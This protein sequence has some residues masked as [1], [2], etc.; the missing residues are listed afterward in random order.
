MST[1]AHRM[2]WSWLR[3]LAC[4]ALAVPSIAHADVIVSEF[5]ASNNSTLESVTGE[6]PDWIEIYNGSAAAV[7]LTGWYL[8]D[9]PDNLRKWR[10][11]ESAAVPPLASGGYL[12]VFASGAEN[13][14]I[15]GEL[16]AG[17]SLSA[18]GEYLALV[19]PDGQTIAFHYAPQFPPQTTAVS[20]GV[21]T[22][23]GRQ[24]FLASPTPGTENSAVVADP[25]HFSVTSRAFTAPFTL[26]LSTGSPDAEIRYTLD[27]SIP[28]ASS[29]LYASEISI[30]ST[31]K[32]RARAYESG[33]AAGPVAS[34]VFHHLLSGPAAFTS[35]LPLVVIETFGAGDIPHP[36][37]PVRQPCAMM[38]IEPVNGVSTL[39]GE[40]AITSRA[41][42]H[43]RGESTLRSTGSKPNLSLETWGEVV[44]ETRRIE[45]FGM[46]AESDWILYAP[47][48]IDTAM[49]RNP[50]IYEVSN[51]AGEYAVR[52]R[53]VEVFLN[54]GGGSISNSDYFGLYVF[55]ER[56]KRREG[57]VEVKKLTPDAI[58][59]PEITGGYIWKKDKSDPDDQIIAAAGKDLIAVYP[60][61]MPAVQSDWLV[62]HLNTIDAAIPHGN[63]AE[64]ID[65]VSFADHH[66]L[67][68]FANNADGLN[69]STFYHK[70]RNGPVRMGPIWDFD[71][72][73]ACDIDA[74]ASNPEVWSLA[75][76]QMFFFH[77]SGPLWFRSL[78]FNSP[79]FWIVWV[80]RWQAMRQGPLSDAAITGRIERHRTEIS[81]A[82]L[83]NY[84]RWS[85]VLNADAWSGKV[86]AMH[87]HVLT[88]AN[89]I[90]D[91]LVT[92]PVFNH[93]G[94]LV[95]SGM[96]LGIS[97]PQSKFFTLDGSDPRAS[98]GSPAG[99]PYTAPITITG[100]TLV[101]ARAWNGQAFVNAPAT[102]PWSALT[103]AMFVVEPVPLAITEIMYHPRPPQSAA[104]AGFSTSDFEFIEIMN[105]GDSPCIL[106]GVKLLD[107]VGFDFTTGTAGV[108]AAGARGVVVANLDAFKARYPHWAT[109]NILGEFTGKLHNIGGK[110][111]L[112]YDTA[113]VIKLADFSYANDWYPLTD[114][115]GHSL[116][117]RGPQSDPTTWGT[118]AAWRHSAAVDGSPGETDTMPPLG[119]LI[120]YWN[121]NNSATLLAPTA[122]TGDGALAITLDDGAATLAGTGQDFFGENARH[123]DPAGS[124]LR[125]NNPLGTT[126]TAALPTSGFSD[127]VVSYETR[128]SGQGA[129]LQ[130]IEVT[131]DGV[132]YELFATIPVLDATPVLRTF[133]FR[134]LPDAS[135]NPSFGM[136]VTFAQ[137]GGSLAGNNRFD[138]LTVTGQILPETSPPASIVFDTIPA[139]SISGSPLGTVVVRL[140]DADG[141][142]AI[143]FNGPV[144]L[145]LLGAGDL[146][147][148]TTVDA[149]F[150]TA[151]FDDLVLT[152]TGS[153]QLIATAAGLDPV[154][155]GEFHSVAL[156][157]LVMPHF[158]QGDQD[159]DDNNLDRVP[160]A[161]RLQL[162]GL[163][164]N[165]TYRYGNRVVL[166]GDA[167]DNNGAG[168]GIYITGA[169]T[170]WIRNTNAPRFREGDLG[171]RHWTFATDSEGSYSGW[172]VTEP[173]GNARF[174]PGNEL[175]M[176]LLLND[177]QGGEATTHI[178]TTASSATV[179]RFGG[180]ADEGTGVVGQTGAAA[181]RMV[182]LYDETTGVS[183]PLA[184]TPVEIT[185]AE[186]DD[187]YV[188]YY[189]TV[190]ATNPQHWGTILPNT[191]ANGLR[192]IEVRGLTGETILDLRVDGDGFP[193]TVNPDSG[194][195]PV[196]L[197]AGAGLARFLPGGD[198]SWNDAVNW[199]TQSVPDGD[200]QSAI[201]N[202]PV[203][204]NRAVTQNAPVTL[205]NLR[206]EQDASPFRNR[207]NSA[208]ALAGLAFANDGQPAELRV[209]GNGPGFVEFDLDAPVELSDTL[210]VIIDHFGNEAGDAFGGLRLRG[211]WQGAGGLIKQGMGVASLTGGGKNFTGTI[212]IE[213]G[214]LRVTEPAVPAAASGVTVLEGGQLRLVS[215]SSPHEP[216]V[217]VFGGGA[218]KLAGRGRGGERTGLEELGVLGALRYDPPHNDNHAVLTNALL[219][220]ADTDIH[221][222]G[223]RNLLELDGSITG[224]GKLIKTGGGALRLAADSPAFGGPLD[225]R[226]GR[227][228]VD[229]DVSMA[230]V[231]LGP[232]GV[233][234]GS[235]AVATV[236]GNGS[237]EPGR[238]R[239]TASQSGAAGYAFV[240]T[241]PGTTAGNGMLKLTHTPALT[242]DPSQI[243]IYLDVESLSPGDVFPGGLQVDAGQDLA[244]TLSA[245]TVNLFLAGHEGDL[246]YLGTEYRPAVE[247][248][249]LSWSVAATA[250]GGLIE[251]RVAAAATG[252][253]AWRE[254]EFTA[255]ELEDESVSGAQAG[256][257]GMGI[258]NL[259]RYALGLGRNDNPALRLPQLNNDLIYRFPMDPAKDDIIYRVVSSPDLIDWSGVIYDSSLPDSARPVDGWIEITPSQSDVSRQ[260]WRLQ[261]EPVSSS[262]P[263]TQ[264]DGPPG[265]LYKLRADPAERDKLCQQPPQIVVE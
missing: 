80:D 169:A 30:N 123:G 97:G 113:E 13:S 84:A 146:S 96:Q 82:A 36:D 125:V 78:A 217:H 11:P 111:L 220:A 69:L 3:L 104:E 14:V 157:E 50:F 240:F 22:T 207:I 63:Y 163:R 162:D 219:L 218:I 198:G 129:G 60:K 138:N 166:A 108:L 18:A 58:A 92:P 259:M 51:E 37:N 149:V 211:I 140:F 8:T 202:A 156:T 182:V 186:V 75:T 238:A 237:V 95:S 85:G 206:V 42:V 45:P 165:A 150:G 114:G 181:R 130:D 107:G 239:L 250:D 116:V 262:A 235:G 126:L 143:T 185:G 264:L 152:G 52:T 179:L 192:R 135:N 21:D 243:D 197:D 246:V 4:A 19:E 9:N 161:F 180:G 160:Y 173:T 184:A 170:N 48:T 24:G 71:R 195:T 72:S 187:R 56:I 200:G 44:G 46:P 2:A 175:H 193:D 28:T 99:T 23:T 210:R 147:G 188:T 41:G 155:S 142:P 245:T 76:D 54:T 103:E 102:W 254:D 34:E 105:T 112:G 124:H 121:F 154:T 67:N 106:T 145:T 39:T 73:M 81:A 224:S 201:L 1:L 68:V 153:F 203:G 261:I 190:V 137:G 223:T 16:H 117:L 255:A 221:V 27:G 257:S 159:L 6:Y 148:T 226:N 136:R 15:G 120:H 83:R 233:L 151:T 225:V 127:I 7:D 133:D 230:A 17:F 131:T 252:F 90:D 171:S 139:G 32:V 213:Q 189:E 183:R 10:I 167:P 59:E 89:W 43:R 174:T 232:G 66:I 227:L 222:D 119:E 263:Q 79:D 93:P 134:S 248:D 55:M 247:S 65:V 199:S 115:I 38:I 101:K 260:F 168:N 29:G 236:S 178:L 231:L 234:A 12:V 208:D 253:N 172:F 249:K 77:S 25:V 110:I 57:R 141:N 53:Y 109:L 241:T 212:V 64:L 204:G 176:R 196:L 242:D 118:R 214:T 26:V 20:Y 177:G 86:D 91:Q 88:R 47:W 62:D 61:N 132:N 49:T 256:P 191:L 40:P 87:N 128:R 5:M 209:L 258:A 164:P 35:D 215:S 144:T 158:I 205:G 100:N 122:T 265:Q 216:R 74:R 229:C 194:T 31:I 244:A 94:G 33:L 70:D 228:D 98:G 251:V